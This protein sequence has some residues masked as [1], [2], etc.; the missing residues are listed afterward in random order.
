LTP[1]TSQQE[2]KKKFENSASYFF[3]FQSSL[4]MKGLT[5]NMTTQGHSKAGKKI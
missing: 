4:K 3:I 2:K 5:A 1:E